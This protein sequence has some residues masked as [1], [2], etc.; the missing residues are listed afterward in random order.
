MVLAELVK[1]IRI[2]ADS[3]NIDCSNIT[4]VYIIKSVDVTGAAEQGGQGGLL[5]PEISRWGG[6]APPCAA[7]RL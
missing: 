1:R 2:S 6:S 5:P 7:I 3:N 4:H